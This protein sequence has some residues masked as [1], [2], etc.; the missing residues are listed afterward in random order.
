[1]D[2][3]L[4]ASM[5][6][7]VG[8]VKELL[9]AGA[10]VD[11][12]SPLYLASERG[13]TDVVELL[14]GAGAVVDKPMP[15][16]PTALFVASERGH[17]GVVKLLLEKGAKACR[18]RETDNVTCL[19]AACSIGKVAV[20]KLLLEAGA[21]PNG[22]G[23]LSPLYSASRNG[24]DLVVELLLEAGADVNELSEGFGALYAAAH[25]RHKNAA[26]ALV[27]RGASLEALLPCHNMVA[28]VSDWRMAA[29]EARV[30][31]LEGAANPLKRKAPETL[32]RKVRGTR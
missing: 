1:M 27:G 28:R 21:Q 16:F 9:A 6:G 14:L 7:D 20:V 24:H 15:G 10:H 25:M 2:S 11:A 22:C 29:L 19:A 30:A 18:A 32:K 13:H 8:L 31:R 3:L 17:A 23:G 4:S 12:L 26:L 5:K